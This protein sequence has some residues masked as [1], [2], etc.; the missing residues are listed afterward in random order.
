MIINLISIVI[1]VYNNEQSISLLVNEIIALFEQKIDTRYEL[2]F[3]NDGSTDGSEKL[4]AK[5]QKDNQQ[6]RYI[7]FNRNFG[8]VA[9]IQAGLQ[10]AKGDAV[11]VMSADMQEPVDLILNMLEK[12]KSGAKVVLAY[13]AE[14]NDGALNNLVSKLF[15]GI[16]KL[17]LPQMP[18]GGFDYC[19]FD[20]DVLHYLN[21]LKYRNRFLQGDILYAGFETAIIPYS[22][23]KG[24]NSN[25]KKVVNNFTFKVKYFIDGVLHTGAYPIRI[26][27]LLGIITTLAGILYSLVI[28]VNWMLGFTP[29]KGWAP[30]MISI[31]VIGGLILFTLGVLGEYI[32]RIY[33]ELRSMPKY[34]IKEKNLND[35]EPK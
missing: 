13:R 27:S 26:I 2:I 4:L 14:R 25:N 5:L 28:V 10:I 20:K 6:V 8:Q 17:S 22:R 34:V 24:L 29:F 21:A 32:W 9:A 3:V 12:Y 15:Y 30:I 16:L 35:S 11:V 23:S 33:D 18:S 7:L 19:L 1:P 31:L